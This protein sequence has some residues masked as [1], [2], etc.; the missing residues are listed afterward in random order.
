MA[1]ARLSDGYLAVRVAHC[2]KLTIK[3]L[4]RTGRAPR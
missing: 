1:L 3:F 4:Y 2:S